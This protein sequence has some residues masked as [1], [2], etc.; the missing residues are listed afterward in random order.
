M[1]VISLSYL[2]SA[3]PELLTKSKETG[4]L[5]V[6]AGVTRLFSKKTRFLT[7]RA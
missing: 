7:T 6:S 4:F 2:D 3:T 5:T 1:W